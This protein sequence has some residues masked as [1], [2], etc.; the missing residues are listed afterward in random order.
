MALSEVT[1]EGTDTITF[2]DVYYGGK[3]VVFNVTNEY[4]VDSLLDESTG[5]SQI[6]NGNIK[7]YQYNNGSNS[8]VNSSTSAIAVMNGAGLVSMDG[9]GL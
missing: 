3:K 6:I 7:I 9:G 1:G 8:P 5:E 2:G 4:S